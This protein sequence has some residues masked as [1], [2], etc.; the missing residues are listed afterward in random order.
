MSTL[1]PNP[2]VRRPS[3]ALPNW[4]NGYSGMERGALLRGAGETESEVV[5]A[6]CGSA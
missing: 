2:R 6:T 1:S 5:A 4:G 3:F